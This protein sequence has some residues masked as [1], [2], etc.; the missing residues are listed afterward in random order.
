M[1]QWPRN[2]HNGE[3]PKRRPK[4]QPELQPARTAAPDLA[5]QRLCRVVLPPD[6]VKLGQVVAG[7]GHVWVVLAKTFPR[8]LNRL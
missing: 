6:A 5:V 4:Q 8:H 7:G 2:K 1:Q 3:L